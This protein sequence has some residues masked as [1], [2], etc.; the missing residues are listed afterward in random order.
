VHPECVLRPLCCDERVQ[1]REDTRLGRRHLLR[2]RVRVR[3]RVRA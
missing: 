3:V 2:V 1:Q